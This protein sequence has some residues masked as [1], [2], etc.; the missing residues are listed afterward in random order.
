MAQIEKARFPDST[1]VD[2]LAYR[3]DEQA[4]EIT[5]V[6]GHVYRYFDVPAAVY[7]RFQAAESAGQFLHEEIL[8]RY[9]F[10]RLK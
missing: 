1:A 5:F 10:E 7:D 9:E 6:S 4:L 8:D 3:A 2:A